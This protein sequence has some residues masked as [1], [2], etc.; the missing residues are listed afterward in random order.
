MSDLWEPYRKMAADESQ[1]TFY[2]ARTNVPGCMIASVCV[3]EFPWPVGTLWYRLVGNLTIEVLHSY[4]IK[5]LR[6][7][8]LRTSLHNYL[9]RLYPSIQWIIT[10]SGSDDGGTA[11]LEHAG[12]KQDSLT[13]DWKLKVSRTRTRKA[14]SR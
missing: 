14:K 6:R 12:F 11:W 4:V 13:F 9:L 5:E 7:C 8:G 10:A 2:W 3:P 1:R